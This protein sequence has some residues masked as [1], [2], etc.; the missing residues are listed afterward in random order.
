MK[1]K[2]VMKKIDK[3][4]FNKKLLKIYKYFSSIKEEK[5]SSSLRDHKIEIFYSKNNQCQLAKLCDLYGSDKGA[6]SA[7]NHPYG[8]YPHTYTDFYDLLFSHRR[9]TVKRILECGIGSNDTSIASNMG[10]DGKPGASLRAWRDYFP[11]AIVTGVDIDEKILFTEERIE[12]Y[13]VDQTSPESIKKFL[14][15]MGPTI[16]DVI[17]DDG[18]HEYCAGI[19]FFEHLISSLAN[20]GIYII[21][22][23]ILKDWQQY[24]AYF[25]GKEQEFNCRFINLHRPARKLADNSIIMITKNTKAKDVLN[26]S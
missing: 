17:I 26:L 16:F 5:K 10:E 7:D 19:C 23:V 18:L 15:K 22:D 20:D 12:T 21:E 24:N 9:A 14:K 3:I 2:F 8:W 6:I 25:L 4:L 1:L 11:E 13:Q